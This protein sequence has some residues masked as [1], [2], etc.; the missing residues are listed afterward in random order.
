M[1]Y[2]NVNEFLSME[3]CIDARQPLNLTLMRMHV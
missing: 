3:D 2:K 1:N